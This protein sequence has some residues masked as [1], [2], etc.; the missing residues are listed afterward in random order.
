MIET[1]AHPPVTVLP[2]PA[3]SP[4]GNT[5]GE[6]PVVGLIPHHTGVAAAVLLDGG[7]PLVA[8]SAA[9]RRGGGAPG[10]A[11]GRGGG[12]AEVLWRRRRAAEVGGGHRG[13]LLQSRV[14]VHFESRSIACERGTAN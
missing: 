2:V 8:V 1:A 3:P 12:A 7:G 4:L 10:V 6:S 14:P 11:P 9:R 13:L 5:V